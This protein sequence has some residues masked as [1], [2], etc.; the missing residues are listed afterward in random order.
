MTHSPRADALPVLIRNLRSRS[1][2]GIFGPALRAGSTTGVL[3]HVRICKA[4]GRGGSVAGGVEEVDAVGNVPDYSTLFL[5]TSL[6]LTPRV[7]LAPVLLGWGEFRVDTQETLRYALTNDLLP[8]CPA[9]Q[10]VL[11]GNHITSRRLPFSS[12]TPS[13]TRA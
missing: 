11:C 6:R 9:I 1:S 8:F 7:F 12:F 5:T 13:F 2:P 3:H 10:G 4:K